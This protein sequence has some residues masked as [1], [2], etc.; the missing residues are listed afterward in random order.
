MSQE[1]DAFQK[2]KDIAE[3]LQSAEKLSLDEVD[4]ALLEATEAYQKARSR[5][6]NTRSL[7]NKFNQS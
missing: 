1:T 3:M 5:I 2:L 7:L 6:D 4:K